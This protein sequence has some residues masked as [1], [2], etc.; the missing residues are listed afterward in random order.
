MKRIVLSVLLL[1]CMGKL[2][3][4]SKFECFFNSLRFTGF[5]ASLPLTSKDNAPPIYI[6]S[7]VQPILQTFDKTSIVSTT[8]YSK[9]TTT[10]TV[11]VNEKSD[12][13]FDFFVLSAVINVYLVV[14]IAVY[15]IAYFI[16]PSNASKGTEVADDIT[17]VW[18]P[19]EENV[20][21]LLE[22][23]N[24]VEVEI[25][26]VAI[27]VLPESFLDLSTDIIP[28]ANSTQLNIKRPDELAATYSWVWNSVDYTED[29]SI[30]NF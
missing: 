27:N 2:L 29:S 30:F 10:T 20:A 11:I 9:E 8:P 28:I 7:T 16:K 4:S 21:Q 12:K 22:S 19:P 3:I 13:Y 1:K 14:L 23:V 24:V 25:P 17:V 18:I 6:V 5:S 26:P 15:L